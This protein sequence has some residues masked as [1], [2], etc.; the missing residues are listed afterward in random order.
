MFNKCG[1]TAFVTPDTTICKG[2]MLILTASGGTSYLWNT[3]DITPS[4]SVSP[5]TTTTYIVTVTDGGCSDIDSVVVTVISPSVDLGPDTIICANWG[6][7]IYAGYIVLDAGP[8][9]KSYLW[10]TGDTTQTFLVDGQNYTLLTTETFY[11]LV[12]DSL[13]CQGVDSVDIFMDICSGV[14]ENTNI[15]SLEVFPNPSKGLFNLSVKG[16]IKN[17]FEL[18]I[19]NLQG[20]KIYCEKIKNINSLIY[21]KQLDLSTYPKGVYFIKLI[22]DDFVKVDKIIIQ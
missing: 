15:I 10:S 9:F 11:V 16:L 21:K 13:D 18:C 5:L 19:L 1:P 8:G 4:I 14:L 3:S 20:Q 2:S 12:T 7:P 22:N 17:D 6:Y